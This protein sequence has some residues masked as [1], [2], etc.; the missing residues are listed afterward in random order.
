MQ[1]AC[2]RVAE[3][4]SHCIDKHAGEDI[5]CFSHMGTI[6]AALTNALSLNLHNSVCFSIDNLSITQIN[7][8]AD[9]HKDAPQFRVLSVSEKHHEG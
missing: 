2:D 8:Y 7:H 9:L 1:D 6:L 4:V 3:F 5:I